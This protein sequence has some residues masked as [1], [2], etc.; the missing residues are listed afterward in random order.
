MAKFVLWVLLAV[1]APSVWAISNIESERPGL[2]KEGW[3]G[4]VEFGIDGETGNSE[5]ENYLFGAKVVRRAGDNIYLGLLSKEYGKTRDI[6]DTDE[7]FAHA[8]WIHIVNAQWAYE[9]FVQAED[10]AFDN[11]QSRILAGGGARYVVAE[12]DDV[13]SL[14]LGF[15]GFRERE[16]LDLGTYEQKTWLWRLNS[17]AVY[18]HRLNDQLNFS[19]TVYYQPSTSDA[20]DFRSLVTAA[21]LVKLTDALNLKVEYELA[22]D[23]EPA[24]NLDAVPVIDKH[25]TNAQYKTTLVYQF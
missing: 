13:F 3:S 10:D 7:S 22:Y 12:N 5:E 11:L 18:K 15:G 24:K 16:V 9:F 21:L 14:A 6:K 17:F 8:R 25:K 20:S 1:G 19:S 23:S 4:Q 2:P